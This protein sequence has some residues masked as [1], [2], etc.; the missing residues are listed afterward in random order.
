MF[1]D[2]LLFGGDQQMTERIPVLVTTAHRGVFFGFCDP[3]E[4]DNK[5]KI[6]LTRIRNC[7][8][9]SADVGGFLGLAATGPSSSCKIGAE[10]LEAVLHDI[11]SCTLCTEGAVAKWTSA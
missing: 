10:A 3:L 4:R 7:I 8:S 11:T 1:D 6:H 9:W 5:A 2:T